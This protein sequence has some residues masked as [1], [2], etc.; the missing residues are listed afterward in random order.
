MCEGVCERVYVCERGVW[1]CVCDIYGWM[2]VR[3]VRM[4]ACARKVGAKGRMGGCGCKREYVG[5]DVDGCVGCVVAK[6]RSGGR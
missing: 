3:G 4:S 1:M 2:C 5:R 6:W